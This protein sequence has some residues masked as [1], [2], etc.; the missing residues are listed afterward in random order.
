[1]KSQAMS[2]ALPISLECVY[3]G[4]IVEEIL[5]KVDVEPFR[6]EQR[7]WT[8]RDMTGPT[9]NDPVLANRVIG[10]VEAQQRD[11]NIELLYLSR[12]RGY[13]AA[14][15]TSCGELSTTRL[16]MS[17]GFSFPAVLSGTWCVVWTSSTVV[18]IK[19]P[20]SF[21]APDE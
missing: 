6:N 4:Q 5:I 18:T 1:M 14:Q 12:R 15:L 17:K 16:L 19:L 11:G 3:H 13:V 21:A 2:T 20:P 7:E 10:I 8:P 9:H